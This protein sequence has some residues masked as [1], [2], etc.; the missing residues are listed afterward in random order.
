VL[1]SIRRVSVLWFCVGAVL[2]FVL[3]SAGWLSNVLQLGAIGWSFQLLA[4]GSCPF[5]L[6]LWWPAMTHPKNDVLFLSVAL[7][8]VL[9]NGCLYLPLAYVQAKTR[10]WTMSARIGAILIVYVLLMI[11]GYCVPLGVE[12]FAGESGLSR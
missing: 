11:L 6:F 2:P 7:G 12:H 5:W 9:A 8:V 1:L 3:W 4:V 10:L